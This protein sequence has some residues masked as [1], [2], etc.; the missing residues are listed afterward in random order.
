M[1]ARKE[2]R[3]AWDEFYWDAQEIHADTADDKTETPWTFPEMLARAV[4]LDGAPPRHYNIVDGKFVPAHDEWDRVSYCI[5]DRLRSA[6]RAVTSLRGPMNSPRRL[7]GSVYVSS[8]TGPRWA[9]LDPG[10]IPPG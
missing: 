6:A 3:P 10:P 8:T 7:V 9:H 5:D 1:L 4:E 2:T